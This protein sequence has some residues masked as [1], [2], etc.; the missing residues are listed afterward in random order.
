MLFG[1]DYYKIVREFTHLLN[2]NEGVGKI[3]EQ[4]KVAKVLTE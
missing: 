4:E 2:N 1:G 3:C